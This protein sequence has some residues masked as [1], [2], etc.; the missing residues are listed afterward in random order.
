MN[1]IGTAFL[2]ALLT[3]LRMLTG[4]IVTKFVAVSVGPTGVAIK[5]DK[6]WSDLLPNM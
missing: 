4:F 3:L 5:S 2:G 6:E 1:L